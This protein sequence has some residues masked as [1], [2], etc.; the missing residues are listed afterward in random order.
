MLVLDRGQKETGELLHR[1]F[2]MQF[3]EI[4][5]RTKEAALAKRTAFPVQRTET[6]ELLLFWKILSHFQSPNPG[7][8]IALILIQ[9]LIKKRRNFGPSKKAK[10]IFQHQKRLWNSKPKQYSRNSNVIIKYL[11]Y[12]RNIG[13]FFD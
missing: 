4:K 7:Y 11:S 6:E 9:S 13:Q 10:N 1:G 8:N 12:C 3:V 5:K 2:R